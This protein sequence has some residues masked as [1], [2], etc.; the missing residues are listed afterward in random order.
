MSRLLV[1]GIDSAEPMQIEEWIDH[2]PH[3]KQLYDVFYTR[4]ESTVPPI[5]I[6]AW[7]TAFS[8]L[9]PGH[10]GLYD[11]RYRLKRS[12]TKYGLYS[13]RLVEDVDFIWNAMSR[14]GF[15]VAL[16]FVPGTYPPP[17]IKGYVISGFFTPNVGSS[18]TWPFRLKYEVLE[19]VGGADKY[20]IDIHDYRRMNPKL[21]YKALIDKVVHD[22][23]V[24]THVLTKYE[25]DLAIAVLMSIDRAQ[26]TLWRFFD[27]EHPRYVKDPELEE[28]L[29]NIYRKI[30]EELG[31]LLEKLPKDVKVI[32]MSDHGAK[33]MHYRINVNEA[34]AEEGLLKLKEKPEK[35]MPL[36]QLDKRGL[37]DWERTI[38]WS[39]GAYVAQVW[40]NL[41]GR[42]A[43]GCVRKEDYED[44]CRQVADFLQSMEGPDGEKLR[45][46]VFFKW[47]IYKGSKVEMM[48]DITVYFDDLHYGANEMIGF[49]SLY[50]L[51]TLKGPDDSNHSERAI[52]M[53]NEKPSI[54]IKNLE[55]VRKLLE[56][57][58]ETI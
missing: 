33:R 38:A 47:E 14:K 52:F 27:R 18:F 45:N 36:G 8:G 55:D 10:F 39:W 51:E 17:K 40:I 5:T 57:L 7:L 11:L 35:P 13:Y 16:C 32:V 53:C 42:E 12:Y 43:K 9:N 3:M 56:L 19:A 1:I 46:K 4:V 37:I 6:P 58:I 41:E 24:I 23:K 25:W 50:S 54:S 34:L 49:N 21:L 26:H 44:T 20:I 28:G 2:L 15:K 22:F 29:L 48:P 30:D 31:K